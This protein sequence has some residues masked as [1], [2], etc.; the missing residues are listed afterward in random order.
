M[1]S[2]RSCS[3]GVRPAFSA[4]SASAPTRRRLQLTGVHL[5]EVLAGRE[6]RPHHGTRRGA[7]DEVG[8]G[9]VHAGVGE[10][11]QQADLPRDAGDATAAE[12]E[13]RALVAHGAILTPRSV[14]D[15]ASDLGHAE[16][17]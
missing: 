11:G 17:R 5:L 1:T 10:P 2:S 3:G 4:A 9:Q 6:P 14:L 15:T 7:D 12:H 16:G 8:A 13:G